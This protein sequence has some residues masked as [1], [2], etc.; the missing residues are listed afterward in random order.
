M[1]TVED[2][3]RPWRPEV[4]GAV[5]GLNAVIRVVRSPWHITGPENQFGVGS[6]TSSR[7]VCST[8]RRGAVSPMF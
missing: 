8:P 6:S 5:I 3:K 2:L 7:A 4:A 1:R